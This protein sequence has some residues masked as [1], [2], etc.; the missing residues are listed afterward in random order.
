[1]V[2]WLRKTFIKNYQDIDDP[3]VRA[4][5]GVLSSILGLLL[6]AVLF[7][8]KF[9]SALLLMLS[10]SGVL[11][12]ALLGDSLNNLFDFASSFI[13]LLGFHIAKKPADKEHPYGHGRAEYVAGLMIG[14]VIIVSAVLLAYRS[15]QGIIH[16]DTTNYDLF[17]YIALASTLPIKGIQAYV[18]FS[19]GKTLRSPTLRGVGIDAL[20]DICLSSLLLLFA[21]LSKANGWTT[22]D[23]YLGL[24]VSAFLTYAGIEVLRETS[25]PLL[26]APMDRKTQKEAESI[27]LSFPGVY[28]VH[29]IIFHN[30]GEGFSYLSFHVEL[31]GELNLK[32]A[33]DILDELEKRVGKATHSVAIAHPDPIDIHDERL[34]EFKR[35]I[36]LLL[37]ELDEGLSCHDVHFTDERKDSLTLDI[38]VPFEAKEGI[39]TEIEDKL[40]ELGVKL[41]INFDHPYSE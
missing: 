34:T 26:G 38:L 21:I 5:H 19:L 28:G 23:N 13:A 36:P 7:G 8:L 17:A 10:T 15:I 22:L 25:G 31:D 27:I 11:S 30:Y 35:R 1:M 14:V 6:N 29:D 3:N 39:K 40:K 4:N 16:G 2:I 33:H 12:L 9:T 41:I 24:L 32:E 18:N 37:K 20:V